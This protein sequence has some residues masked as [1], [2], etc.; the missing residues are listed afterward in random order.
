[1]ARTEVSG[2]KWNAWFLYVTEKQVS[3]WFTRWIKTGIPKRKENAV[4]TGTWSL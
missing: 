2:L 3:A 4:C 1:M